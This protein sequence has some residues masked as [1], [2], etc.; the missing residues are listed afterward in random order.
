MLVKQ[1][2]KNDEYYKEHIDQILKNKKTLYDKIEFVSRFV[3]IEDGTLIENLKNLP[4]DAELIYK[5]VF[6]ESI[7][8]DDVLF[9]FKFFYEER[10]NEIKEI[11]E[12]IKKEKDNGKGLKV[13]KI[14]KKDLKSCLEY[15]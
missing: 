7:N 12:Q 10:L 13:Q 2:A 1:K 5:Y 3:D 4:K 9:G 14:N 11:C 15:E 8:R 6:D